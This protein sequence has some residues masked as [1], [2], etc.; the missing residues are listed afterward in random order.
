MSFDKGLNIIQAVRVINIWH[1]N[2]FKLLFFSDE[3]AVLL[4]WL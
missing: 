2:D 3:F 1:N 4:P